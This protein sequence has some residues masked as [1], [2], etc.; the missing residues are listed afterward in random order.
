LTLSKRERP[1]SRSLNGSITS[2]NIA[3]ASIRRWSDSI[4]G[5]HIKVDTPAATTSTTDAI[6]TVG[7][8][9]ASASNR[10]SY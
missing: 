5:R 9:H 3:K 1:E 7:G 4:G 6:A 2:S 10:I 8:D